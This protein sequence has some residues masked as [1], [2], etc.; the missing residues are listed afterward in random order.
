MMI[1]E[2]GR[3]IAMEGE[4]VWIETQQ[5]SA[6]HSCAAKA[7]CGQH[8][9]SNV[10]PSKRQHLK[11]STRTFA[12]TVQLYDNVELAIPEQSI[13]KGAFLLYGLPLLMLLLGTVAASSFFPANDAMAGLGAFIGFSAAVLIVRGHAYWH[14]DDP[15][16]H[17]MIKRIL[18]NVAVVQHLSC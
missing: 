10:F 9:L 16:Y 7:G 17:P 2:T 1:C 3:I 15:Q 11:L 18:P 4:W 13:V 14:R 6:C 8:L 12:D 5:M